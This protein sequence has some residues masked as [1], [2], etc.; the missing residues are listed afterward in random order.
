MFMWVLCFF[1]P[2]WS[3]GINVK[4][5]KR[6]QYLLHRPRP[7]FKSRLWQLRWALLFHHLCSGDGLNF[8]F[9]ILGL[10]LHKG[11]AKSRKKGLFKFG[12]SREWEILCQ[13]MQKVDV[14]RNHTLAVA[15]LLM[16][17]RWGAGYC[18][19]RAIMWDSQA[20]P[21]HPLPLPHR[22]DW[23]GTAWAGPG[24]LLGSDCF[25]P[26]ACLWS[27]DPNKPWSYDGPQW[28]YSLMHIFSQH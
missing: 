10:Y 12:R 14:L 18:A 16:P 3:L 22:C 28:R 13:L 21:G 23:W 27:K 20:H 26:F 4:F 6:L 9:L 19:L 25:L 2:T 17:W 1:F 24:K 7:G 11:R 15:G 5:W 8:T